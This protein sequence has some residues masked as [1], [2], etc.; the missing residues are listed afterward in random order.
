[1][2]TPSASPMPPPEPRPKG[3]FRQNVIRFC[4]LLYEIGNEETRAAAF[5][6]ENTHCYMEPERFKRL[7]LD[8]FCHGRKY[9]DGSRYTQGGARFSKRN[10]ALRALNKLEAGDH[11]ETQF[12]ES[13]KARKMKFYRLKLPSLD[14][15][16]IESDNTHEEDTAILPATVIDFDNSA[17]RMAIKKAQVVIESDNGCYP[18]GQQGVIESG[19]SIRVSTSQVL[20]ESTFNAADCE[21]VELASIAPLARASEEARIED[22]FALSEEEEDGSPLEPAEER[23]R[24]ENYLERLKAIDPQRLSRIDQITLRNRIRR[25]E[26][27]LEDLNTLSCSP[28]PAL[29]PPSEPI[30]VPSSACLYEDEQVTIETRTSG[31]NFVL[32]PS[33]DL[34]P[35]ALFPEALPEPPR[36]TIYE[37]LGS[38]FYDM[39]HLGPSDKQKLAIAAQAIAQ[40]GYQPEDIP[41][42]YGYWRDKFRD[43]KRAGVMHFAQNIATV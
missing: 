5:I 43:L 26:R 27:H 33:D 20:K 37:V 24:L 19:N 22:V 38:F 7:T 8:E 36:P 17:Q 4:H 10:N 16:V 14:H 23:A 41:E 42:K 21:T 12:D 39:T 40:R 1:M 2:S 25:T 32:S 31:A 15:G 29:A 28:A 9:R 11:A 6:F 30:N 13:D 35:A 34:P 3:E 18:N